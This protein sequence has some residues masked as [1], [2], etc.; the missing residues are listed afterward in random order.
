MMFG[1]P[2]AEE[3]GGDFELGLDL[4]VAPMHKQ[5]VAEAPKHPHAPH[6]FGFAAAALV[7]QRREVQSLV[8]SA[9]DVGPQ[10]GL[11]VFDGQQKVSA[12]FEHQLARGLS[13][14]VEGVQTDFAPVPA[15]LFEELARPG[16]FVGLGVHDGVAQVVWLGTVTAVSTE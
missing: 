11:V 10:R 13:L 12:R 15:E 3:I 14:G 16:D 8:Q 1:V 9:F 2:G 7:V 6:G 5:T 4:S